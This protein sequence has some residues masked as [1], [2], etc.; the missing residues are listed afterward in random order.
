MP[1]CRVFRRAGF[2]KLTVSTTWYCKENNSNR[3]HAKRQKADLM[4]N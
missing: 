4:I 1:L 3:Y 2:K